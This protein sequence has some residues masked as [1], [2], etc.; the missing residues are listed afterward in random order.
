MQTGTKFEQLKT[1]HSLLRRNLKKERGQSGKRNSKG[2]RNTNATGNRNSGGNAT[3]S[4]ICISNR[5]IKW[6]LKLEGKLNL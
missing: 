2:G 5:N 3:K 4:L 1:R 6:E